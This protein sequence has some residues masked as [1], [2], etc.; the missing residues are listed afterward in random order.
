MPQVRVRDS[1]GVLRTVAQIRMRDEGNILR[2]IQRIRMRDSGNVLRTV[3]QFFAASIPSSVSTTNTGA[4]SSGTVTTPSQA[5]TVTGGTSPY[6]YAWEF[7]SGSAAIS[8][9]SPTGSSTTFSA[10]VAHGVPETA[11][12]RCKVTDNVGNITYSND[13]YV[14]LRWIDTT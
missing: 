8:I 13:I 9:T 1:S 10:L 14:F 11:F 3:W 4:A 6:T 5:V 12:F 2:T 7:V